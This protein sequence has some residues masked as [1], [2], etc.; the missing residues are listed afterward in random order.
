[1]IPPGLFEMLEEG[2]KYLQRIIEGEKD[3]TP[4]SFLVFAEIVASFDA[5]GRNLTINMSLRH[6]STVCRRE[7]KSGPE[8]PTLLK[9]HWFTICRD[10]LPLRND[11]HNLQSR[12]GM[13]FQTQLRGGL[14]H[15]V[16]LHTDSSAP[17]NVTVGPQIHQFPTR[18]EKQCQQKADLPAQCE[19]GAAQRRIGRCCPFSVTVGAQSTSW[20]IPSAVRVHTASGSTVASA[21]LQGSK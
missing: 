7:E 21:L 13:V 11:S 8:W 3:G 1:M 6:P 10:D 4:P 18:V 14:L 20:S 5:S 17:L 2:S 16:H 19:P 12:S 15:I 9:L